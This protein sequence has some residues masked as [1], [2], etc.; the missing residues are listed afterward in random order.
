MQRIIVAGA[1]AVG[2]YLAGRLSSGGIETLLLARGKRVREIANNKID[3]EFAG[4]VMSATVP[5]AT[6]GDGA[7]IADVVFL[8]TKA[9]DVEGSLC[10]LTT[11]V[12]PSTAIVTLQNG[13]EAPQ[14]IAAKFPCSP[15]LAAR[16]HGFFELH[17]LRVRHVGVPPSLVF[18]QISGTAAGAV[19]QVSGLLEIAGIAATESSDIEADLW[20]KL[21]LASSL[22]GIGAATGLNVGGLR[23]DPAN[24]ALFKAAVREV[25]AVAYARGVRVS[26]NCAE[27]TLAFVAEFPADATT[28]MH[29]DLEARRPSEYVSLTGAV[30]RMAAVSRISVPAHKEIESLIRQRGLLT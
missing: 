14:L 2:S 20:E 26:E 1:G 8:C 5:V 27:R 10:S 13:V 15:V 23:R 17:G 21:V 4:Q 22:G 24:W 12:G 25:I 28:S 11:N 19:Q 3:I 29:R 6:T 9:P 16:L 30:I 7:G 18:G